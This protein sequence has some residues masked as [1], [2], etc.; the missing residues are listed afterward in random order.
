[1][2]GVVALLVVAS[3]TGCSHHSTASPRSVAEVKRAFAGHGI[4]LSGAGAR[5]MR[6]PYVA[7]FGTSGAL[8]INVEVYR[9]PVPRRRVLLFLGS[10]PRHSL[11]ARNVEVT[12]TGADSPRARAAV[13]ELR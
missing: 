6:L 4:T 11:S 13:D 1:M 2:R 9:P 8:S 10:G 5:P 3:V 12:W 7:L